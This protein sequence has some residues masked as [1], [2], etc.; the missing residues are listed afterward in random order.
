[1]AVSIQDIAKLRKLTGAGMMDVKKALEEAAGDFDKAIE[2]IRK[3]GLAI[4]AKRSDREAEEG[5]VLAAHDGDF[6]VVVGLKCETDFVAINADFVA[7]TKQ[8]LEIALQKRGASKEE[9]LATTIADGRSIAELIAERSGVS[10]EKMELGIYEC[11]KGAATTSYIHNGNRI[12][13]I[14]AFNEA[15]D[16]Q[17]ARN[18][19]MQIAAMNPVA[20]DENGV[21][22][23]VKERELSIARDKAR[24]AGKP[25]N[26]LD[27]IAQGALKKYYKENTLL[28]QEFIIDSKLS[29]AQYLQQ[30]SKS[31]TVSAFYRATLV[32]E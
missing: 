3:R 24:E 5:C 10:G 9:I 11:I 13:T 21:P 14:V 23:E 12:A 32:A 4:A 15:I 2:L 18:I 20:I 31:L 22:A 30:Q 6:A 28:E 25:E 1:M 19:A 26:L 17:A 16:A 7:L 27:H 29:V 8:I